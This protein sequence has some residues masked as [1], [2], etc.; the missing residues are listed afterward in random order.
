MN[1]RTISTSPW[2]ERPTPRQTLAEL[3]PQR[4]HRSG[5]NFRLQRS[6][7]RARRV[8]FKRCI[9]CWRPRLSSTRPRRS[10]YP[11]PPR[12]FRLHRQHRRRR[13]R[14]RRWVGGSRRRRRSRRLRRGFGVR[15]DRQGGSESSLSMNHPDRI[16]TRSKTRVLRVHEGPQ[17]L[18]NSRVRPLAMEGPFGSYRAVL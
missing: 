5:S 8:D 4:K 16:C 3:V 17:P 14:P 10:P 15:V 1:H 2:K 12:R 6:A 7:H 11:P 13:Q 18:V 9:S